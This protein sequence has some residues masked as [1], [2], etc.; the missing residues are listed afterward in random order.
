MHEIVAQHAT[1]I[2]E[3]CRQFGVARLE[4]FGSAGG[5]GAFDPARSDIDLLVEFASPGLEYR[6]FFDLKA[7]LEQ[8][9][10]RESTSWSARP[11]NKAAIP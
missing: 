6:H 2:A 7:A 8:V 3:L 10:G 5:G 9:I 4:V 11:S 1:R